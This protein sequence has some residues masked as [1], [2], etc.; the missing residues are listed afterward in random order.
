[1]SETA[2]MLTNE[3]RLEILEQETRKKEAAPDNWPFEYRN[4]SHVHVPV[5]GE[6][7]T[8]EIC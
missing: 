5:K 8:K 6:S 1:M 4:I 7:Y 2:P 3:Q